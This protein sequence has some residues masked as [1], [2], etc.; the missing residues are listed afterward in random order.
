MMSVKWKDNKAVTV[1]T[2]DAVE[3]KQT[4]ACWSLKK[5]KRFPFPSLKLYKHTTKKW[6]ELILWMQPSVPCVP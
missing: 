5:R 1:V 2:N 4:A 6:E 3:P